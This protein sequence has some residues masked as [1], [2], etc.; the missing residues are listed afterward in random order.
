V[1]KLH[2]SWSAVAI[3]APIAVVCAVLMGSIH[4]TDTVLAAKKKASLQ[5][6]F[7]TNV[8]GPN[9]GP[10][11]H[12]QN[13][14]LNISSVRINP[15]PK[16]NAKSTAVPAEGNGS[17]VTIPVPSGVGNV[18][19]GNP[20]D[21][22]VDMI[23]G[24]SQ[25]QYYN[26]GSVK[27][28]T[29]YTVEVE[30]DT[31][32]PGFVVPTCPSGGPR[33]GCINYP[34]IFQNPG[35]QV[36]FSPAQGLQV[37]KGALNL[38]LIQINVSIVSP[39]SGPGQPY[40]V[41]VSI[42]QGATGTYL[43]V[44]SGTVS[45]ASSALNKKKVRKLSVTAELPGTNTVIASAPVSSNG[46]YNFYLPAA[47]SGTLY[48]LYASGGGG[49]YEAIR[50]AT[51][52][53]PG[54]SL[55]VNFDGVTTGHKLG[56]ITGVITDQCTPQSISGATLQLLIPPDGTSGVDCSVTPEQCVS[57][58]TTTTDNVG[59]FP[60]PGTVTAPS[61]FNQIPTDGTYTL[62]VSA[63][64][65]D[66]RLVPGVTATSGK[67]KGSGDCGA[68]SSSKVGCDL[69]LTT[70]Y[71][72]GTVNLGVT[73]QN[74]ENILLQVF[75]ENS[76]TSNLVS[77]LPTPLL[78]RGPNSTATFTLNVPTA[79]SM[80]GGTLDL[81]A[82]AIDLYLGAGDPYTGHSIITASG[83]PVPAAACTSSSATPFAP[84]AMECTG[85]GSIAG[86][87]ANPD[88]G[89]TVALSKN[90]VI[91]E[92]V[93]GGVPQ[94]APTISQSNVYSFCAP[95]DT[96]SVQ[97]YEDGVPQ[98]TASPVGAMATPQATTTPCPSTCFSGTTGSPP[99]PFCPSICGA[100]FGPLL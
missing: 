32:V 43:G 93:P 83:V 48:D 54:G 57:V 94:P 5:V 33:E 72:N 23:A 89:T 24:Q 2:L 26:T 49:S 16:P 61:P 47:P 55:S 66:T 80:P 25:A 90:G 51:P 96:Y 91:L 64:G 29:Y 81:F 7:V 85:H 69:S 39:P 31:A 65:Y 70:G 1:K 40:T 3:L 98:G 62:E 44:V 30:F 84:Q 22:Q 100:T 82:Q 86:T 35:A 11:E 10:A 95:P 37:T 6:A 59:G 99:V 9:G 28:N 63:S 76:G 79:L 92:T 50:L 8:T 41:D 14:F 18:T 75:A 19:H 42:G 58:A 46:N 4:G 53:T 38:L 27:Q 60:L 45:N 12:F 88:T 73:P 56:S 13:L 15:K 67:S 77:A 87:V 36:V 71:V 68:A 34:V 17:W 97:R 78:I 21:L 74:G 20:G 52:L